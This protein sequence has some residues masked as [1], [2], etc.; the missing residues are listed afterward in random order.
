MQPKQVNRIFTRAEIQDYNLQYTPGSSMTIR[1][2]EKHV[3]AKPSTDKIIGRFTPKYETLADAKRML[4]FNED[5][6]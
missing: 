1:Y 4:M 5:A 2:D 3:I 6:S